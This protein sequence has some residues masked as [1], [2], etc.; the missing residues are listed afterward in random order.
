VTFKH[1]RLSRA[2]DYRLREEI[3]HRSY[4]KDKAQNK[5]SI[6]GAL[7]LLRALR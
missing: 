2:N 4:K 6:L 3:H 1:L 7:S 5:K